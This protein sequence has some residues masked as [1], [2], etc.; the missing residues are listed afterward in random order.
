MR[1]KNSPPEG[2]EL[3]P[4]RALCALR[5]P[6]G[7]CLA[8]PAWAGAPAALTRLGFGYYGKKNGGVAGGS[9]PLFFSVGARDGVSR[10]PVP[11]GWAATPAR[12]EQDICEAN[13]VVSTV[14]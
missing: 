6:D 10:H 4:L 1:K 13:S 7:F 5:K 8:A 3:S 12:G 9:K 2:G 14:S 11:E